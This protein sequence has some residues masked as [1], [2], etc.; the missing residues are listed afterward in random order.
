MGLCH[1][2]VAG[3]MWRCHTA[4]MPV[5]LDTLKNNLI[6]ILP[7]LMKLKGAGVYWFHLARLFVRLSVCGQNHVCS[8]LCLPQHQTSQIHFIIYTSLKIRIFGNFFKFVTLTKMSCV[9][10]VM[11]MLKLIPDLSFYCSHF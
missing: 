1:E 11:R 4:Y 9:H 2:K 8:V 7:S 5:I 3:Q 10:G 6:I